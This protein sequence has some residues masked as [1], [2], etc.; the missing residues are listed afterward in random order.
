MTLLLATAAATDAFK[1]RIPLSSASIKFTGL[2]TQKKTLR[3][4]EDWKCLALFAKRRTTL[5]RG[6][7]SQEIADVAKLTPSDMITSPAIEKNDIIAPELTVISAVSTTDVVPRETSSSSA[8]KGRQLSQR[9]QDD[10][11]DFERIGLLN[12][13]KVVIEEGGVTKTLK[14]IFAGVFIADF[15]LVIGFLIWFLAAAAMQ[16]T[17][18]FLLERFQVL[19]V[20]LHFKS[21]NMR[22]HCNRCTFSRNPFMTLFPGHISTRGRSILDSA[23]GGEYGIRCYGGSGQQSE[24]KTIVLELLHCTTG[25]EIE[26]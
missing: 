6:R 3:L 23:Y 12:E 18:P 7:G 9:I 20:L 4:D 2:V 19:T 26:T 22:H 11:S 25:I 21:N 8:A 14:N 1:T 17:N 15:F 10:I 16:K 5:S 24:V 13:K